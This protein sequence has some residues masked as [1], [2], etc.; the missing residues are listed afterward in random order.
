MKFCIGVD[1]DNTIACYDQVFFSLARTLHVLDESVEPSKARVKERVLSRPDGDLIWQKMQG[2]AYGRYMYLASVFP[3]FIEFLYLSRIKGHSVFVVSHKSEYGH[4]DEDRVPLRDSAMNWMRVHGLVGTTALSLNEDEVFFEQTRE[5]KVNRIRELGCTHFI[6]DLQDVFVE[7]S[8]PAGTGKVLFDPQRMA[9]SDHAGHMASS[10][11]EITRS[12]LGEWSD[13][14]VCQVVRA[15]F[16]G[17]KVQQAELK[18]GRGNSRIYRLTGSDGEKYALKVYPDRQLDGRQRLQTEFSACRSLK[19]SGFPVTNALVEDENLG[20]AV[21]EWVS[22][23]P[24][25]SEDKDFVDE[26]ARF[27]EGLLI[28]SRSSKGAG[29]FSEAS[30]ACLSGAEIVRQIRARLGQ[31]MQVESAELFHFLN[32]EFLPALEDSVQL[33]REHAGDVFDRSL[34][35]ELQLLSPSDFGAH[36]AIRNSAGR[37]VFIDLEY[38][39]WDDPV[40]LV[41]DF[42]WHPGMNLRE[43][44]KERWIQCSKMVFRKDSSFEARLA[45]YLPLFALRW[46]LILLN[47]FLPCRLA[48][49]IHADSQNSSDKITILSTQLKKSRNLLMQVIKESQ[50]YGSAL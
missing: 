7:P 41:C 12:L 43:E 24:I 6:D 47:E 50:N 1:F 19:A 42:Y 39:G 17:L 33:A 5:L 46:C 29:E 4:F 18:K 34:P 40:K 13:A 23:T 49:R 25:Q 14:E 11:R 27:V 30:E 28:E 45:A 44:L 31:L 21:Y 36:N 20:W 9:T 15:R 35:R 48:H 37:T 3:G 10:W 16:P 22:G 38:F 8:F 26:A 2:Q 32:K